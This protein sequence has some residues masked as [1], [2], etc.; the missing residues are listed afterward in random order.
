MKPQPT[1]WRCW[2]P[3]KRR[4][5]R[6]FAGGA[7]SRHPI[8]VALAQVARDAPLNPDC[9]RRLIEA[10]RIDQRQPSYQT[11]QDV[12]SYCDYSA[13]PVGQMVLAVFGYS[14]AERLAYS[15]ATCTALQL[16][17]HW[18]DVARD[19]RAGRIYL[20][21]DDLARFGVAESQIPA[22]Q[23]DDNFRA[24]MQ[25]EV[26][27]TEAFFREGLPLIDMVDRSLRVDLQL[28]SDGG[29][30]VLRAIAAQDYD[31]LHHRPTVSGV[32]KG[33]LALRALLRHRLGM[34]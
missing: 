5:E 29:R 22:K 6:A 13:N 8:S 31:V 26:D 9:F 28:F 7:E 25:F 3:G 12:L 19:Y 20:P 32:R 16:A 2:T 10:N 30:A 24:L 1:A 14:D 27:R 18:Q 33:G 23:C 11:F 4:T 17:N 34:G 15:D 21:R